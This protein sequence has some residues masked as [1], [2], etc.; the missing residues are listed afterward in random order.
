[1]ILAGLLGAQ[2]LFEAVAS[3]SSD[4]ILVAGFDG[5]ARYVSPSSR[6]L[7]GYDPEDLL[8][9]LTLDLIHPQDRSRLTGL[10]RKLSEGES[11]TSTCRIRRKDGSYL[12]LESTIRFLRDPVTAGAIEV[13][14]VSRDIT[15]RKHA[16]EK[17]DV[18]DA[19]PHPMIMAGADG[20]IARANTQTE[21]LFGHNRAELVGQP[22]E[23]LVPERFRAGHRDGR[24]A[25][26]AAPST[27]AMGK[28]GEL[29]ALCRDGREIPVEISLDPIDTS[30][31][32]FVMISIIDITERKKSEAHLELFRA[33]VEGA[34]DYG[35]FALDP[36]GFVL[37]WNEGAARLKGYSE[38]EI[39][40][41][42]FSRF[43][44]PEDAAAGRPAHSLHIALTEG[45]FTDE[46]WRVRRNGSRFWAIVVIT[47]L[48]NPDG[49]VRGFSKLVRDITERKRH[50]EHLRE[51]ARTLELL[52]DAMPQMVWT[53]RP[54]GWIDYFNDRWYA[55][56]GSSE[57]LKGDEAWASMLHPDDLEPTRER[58]YTAINSGRTYEIQLRLRNG[59]TGDYRWYLARAMPQRD[60]Q[61]TIVK[62]IGTATDIDDYTRLSDELE[63]R[64]EERT[65][66]LRRSLAE[67]TTLLQEVHHRVKNNLQ[68]ICSLLTMQMD[69]LDVEIHD[70][71]LTIAHSRVL[72]M[73]LIHEQ[74]YQSSTLADL[75]FGEYI[76]L[77]ADR[78]FGAYCVSP[79]R[80]RLEMRVEPIHLTID[81]AIPCG[82][83]LNEL[84]NNSL[85]HA[86]TDGRAGVIR[87]TL[88][89]TE[90]DY[91]ELT[92]SDSGVGLPPG[93][94]AGNTRSLGLQV[95]QTLISQLRAELVITGDDGA[96][97]SFRW[98]LPV[99]TAGS[100][101][102]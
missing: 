44:T 5:I 33:M 50:E 15:A 80:I 40:G 72:A 77:L 38:S 86:F 42:H 79:S 13:L 25:F 88:E 96:S 62:W 89:R 67:K 32:Q 37:S 39:T 66:E 92:V 26:Y 41:Q 94:Q 11:C 4:L 18:I 68:I 75:N 101:A 73:S 64:V 56:T 7:T 1:M 90:H 71:P 16:Q 78:L 55:F 27:R 23:I 61:G 24:G 97:F 30:E 100:T 47:A 22:V 69:S 28:R 2:T 31:G 95:V 45:R 54:D 74:I 70:G 48:L 52:A 93:F 83:I 17:T 49:S 63:H 98:K 82:L 87:I 91:V 76:E 6:Q 53:A 51:S 59:K 84:V 65:T 36:D 58:W 43:Y 12:W 3:N 19:A 60:D 102:S 85:K 29:L 20:L 81:Q 14:A 8:G 21:I 10:L 46:G 35:I 57:E 9:P 34:K 99:S